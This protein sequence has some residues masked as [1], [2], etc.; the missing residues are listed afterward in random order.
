MAFDFLSIIFQDYPACA[1]FS[2]RLKVTSEALHPTALWA[3]ALRLQTHPPPR[4]RPFF[5]FP[6]LLFYPPLYMTSCRLEACHGNSKATRTCT[7]PL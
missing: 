4:L 1:V 7:K 3:C 5:L 2:R 6:V